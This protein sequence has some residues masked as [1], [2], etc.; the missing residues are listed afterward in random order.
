MEGGRDWRSSFIAHLYLPSYRFQIGQ[1]DRRC[2]Q[3]RASNASGRP[4]RAHAGANS[5]YAGH[6]ASTTKMFGPLGISF[7]SQVK[8]NRTLYKWL[9]P[10]ANWYASLSGYRRMG[11]KYDDLRACTLCGEQ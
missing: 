6:L 10:V 5:L 11:L 7:A 4:A 1:L 9:K 2:A 8:A 3:T